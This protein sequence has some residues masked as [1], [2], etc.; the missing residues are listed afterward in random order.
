MPAELVSEALRRVLVVRRPAAGLIVHFDL[1]SQYTSDDFQQLLTRHKAVASMSRKGNC[2]DNAHAEAFWSRLKTELLDGG[3]FPD[4]ET[5]P[6]ELSAYIAYYNLTRRHS[7]LD[8]R[9][10][11]D[12]EAHM[13]TKSQICPA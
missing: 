3:A 8:Y 1:G 13:L 12:F 11:N 4:L 9:S 7:A 6:L 10:P 2:Y 5:A